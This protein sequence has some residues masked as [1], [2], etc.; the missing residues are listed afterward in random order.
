MKFDQLPLNRSPD[1]HG[2]TEYRCN[3]NVTLVNSTKSVN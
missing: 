3:Y 1:M 2:I